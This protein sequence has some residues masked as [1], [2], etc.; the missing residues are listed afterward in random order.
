MGEC[1]TRNF[2]QAMANIGNAITCSE[3]STGNKFLG[4][5]FAIV[6]PVLLLLTL[7]IVLPCVSYTCSKSKK[8]CKRS[9]EPKNCYCERKRHTCPNC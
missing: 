8:N 1:L 9:N 5:L 6:F 4:L 7:T 3:N 2:M